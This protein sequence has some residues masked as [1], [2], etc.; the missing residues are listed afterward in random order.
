MMRRAVIAVLAGFV[1]MACSGCAFYSA[2]VKPPQGAFTSIEA[3]TSTDFSE[4]TPAGTDMGRS[5]AHSILGLVA[6]GDASVDAAARNG[7]LSAVNYVDYEYL[8][9]LG[10]YTKYTTVAHGK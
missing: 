6:W 4:T 7:D 9:V 10:L 2:P 1:L 3:P 8:S 5:S